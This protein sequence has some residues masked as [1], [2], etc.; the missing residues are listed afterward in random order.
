[1]P[2]V[3]HLAEHLAIPNAN[4]FWGASGGSVAPERIRKWSAS[5]EIAY[6]ALLAGIGSTP[7]A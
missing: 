2:Q 6:A 1:M 4:S 7:Q 5:F 3:Y